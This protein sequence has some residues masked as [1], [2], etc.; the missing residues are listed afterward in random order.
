MKR[1]P[2]KNKMRK[3][4]KSNEAYKYYVLIKEIGIQPSELWVMTDEQ[5]MALLYWYNEEI[6]AKQ[7]QNRRQG[8]GM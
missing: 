8:G 4:A 5:V 7:K 6:K 3:I 1:V 2:F